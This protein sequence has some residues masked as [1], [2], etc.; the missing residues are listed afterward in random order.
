MYTIFLPLFHPD[1]IRLI[2][3]FIFDEK[4]KNSTTKQTRVGGRT[5]SVYIK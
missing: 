2:G 3:L 4:K 5:T 1:R